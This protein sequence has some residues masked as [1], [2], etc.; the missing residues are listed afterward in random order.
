MTDNGAT[1]RAA[2]GRTLAYAE[3]GDPDGAPVFYFHVYQG[4]I[5]TSTGWGSRRR[6][7]VQAC[8]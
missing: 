4:R 7:R 5:P 3:T 1:V 6:S 2:S 8:D